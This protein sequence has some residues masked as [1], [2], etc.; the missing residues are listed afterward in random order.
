MSGDGSID[1]ILES[2]A[3]AAEQGFPS[4]WLPQIFGADALTV[5]GALGREVPGIDLGTA[6][7]PTYPRHPFAMAQAGMSAQRGGRF[8]LGIGLSHQIVIEGMFGASFA[9]PYSHMKEYLS[10]LA[11]LIR[12]GRA[13][14][15]GE[16]YRVQYE[17][18]RRRHRAPPLQVAAVARRCWRSPG[19]GPTARSPG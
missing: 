14:F 8:A 15:D 13:D 6:V 10:V 17:P 1:R 18:R 12:E 2:A 4:F 11:P 7:V 5:I 16:E 9:K 19:V 3:E